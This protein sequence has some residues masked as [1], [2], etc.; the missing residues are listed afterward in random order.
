MVGF[1]AVGVA[2]GFFFRVQ[3]W[4]TLAFVGL[5]PPIWYT[6]IGRYCLSWAEPAG[7]GCPQ[8]PWAEFTVNR[9]ADFFFLVP[10]EPAAAVRQR[11]DSCRLFLGLWRRTDAVQKVH[12]TAGAES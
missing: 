11:G 7:I 5:E 4:P 9:E 8:L 3:G 1:A 10:G 12:A 2:H 6:C